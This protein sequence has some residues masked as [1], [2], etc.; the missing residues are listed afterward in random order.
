MH[1]IEYPFWQRQ[2]KQGSFSSE[3]LGTIAIYEFSMM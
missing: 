1:F 3:N 2:S